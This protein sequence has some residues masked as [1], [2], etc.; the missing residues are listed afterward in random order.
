MNSQPQKPTSLRGEVI[1]RTRER[2]AT[3]IISVEA[4]TT[5]T[6][7]EHVL[8]LL[9]ADV[10]QR[11]AGKLD[12]LAW[13]NALGNLGATIHVSIDDGFIDFRLHTIDS[14]VV[15]GTRL[16]HTLFTSPHFTQR[17]LTR[18]K[19]HLTDMLLLS[20]EDSRMHSYQMF[21][22]HVYTKND[23]R[24]VYPPHLLLNEIQKVNARD[25][26]QFHA[27]LWN[28]NWI[29][30][31]GGNAV[32]NRAVQSVVEKIYSCQTPVD[33]PHYVQKKIITTK[34]IAVY[35]RNIPNKQNIDFSIGGSLPLTRNDS[36][37]PAFVFGM[38]VLA[39]SGGFAGRLMSIVREKEG[40][41]YGIYGKTEDITLAEEGVW[42]IGTFFSPRDA[43]KGLTSTFRELRN[44]HEKGITQDELRRFK[45]I[46]TTRYTLIQD[47]L[48]KKVSEVHTLQTLGITSDMYLAYK[49]KINNLSR[50]EVNS[51][52]KKYLN[53]KNCIV[54]GAGPVR[55]VEK[56]LHNL[57]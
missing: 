34:G 7:R 19:K 13:Q 16:L 4:H 5:Y 37:Y 31:I 23:R 52:L 42:R 14:S 57:K 43:M 53:P 17:E 11:G 41:T 50:A 56:E 20:E 45:A 33:V 26:Q 55:K 6:A 47:S 29:Y 38:S 9:Y 39:I 36:D 40:L 51:A 15:E 54:S 24:M 10:I 22:E 3:L 35:T 28:Y 49:E 12:K 21:I 30:T 32:S 46:L 25:I 8:R 18:A 48:L 27:S 44:I 2:M 1:K